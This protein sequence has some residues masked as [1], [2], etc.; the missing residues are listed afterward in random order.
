MLTLVMLASACG[1]SG[2][3]QRITSPPEA[4]EQATPPARESQEREP[5]TMPLSVG[6]DFPSP[7]AEPGAARYAL[8]AESECTAE[9]HWWRPMPPETGGR[10]MVSSRRTVNVAGEDRQLVTTSMFEDQ[11][12]VVDAMFFEGDGW[13]ARVVFRG[14]CPAD[15]VD[16]FLGTI[17]I[18]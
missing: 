5:G 1:G 2:E 7:G 17:T 14:D 18:P 3:R 15:E 12:V 11:D 4:T 6:L 9:L 13:T 8:H 16:R 10:M